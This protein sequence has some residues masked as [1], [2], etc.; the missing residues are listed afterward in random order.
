MGDL[1]PRDARC[2]GTSSTSSTS[3]TQ[4][5]S[6]LG[7]PSST[8]W[9]QGHQLAHAMSFKFPVFTA[10]HLTQV[11]GPRVGARAISLLYS[12]LS[13][14]PSWRSSA[15]ETLKHSYFRQ[16]SQPSSASS[17]H[18]SLALKPS[19]SRKLSSTPTSARS[20]SPPP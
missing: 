18:L 7:T 12:T 5:C 4:V 1:T 6:V 17:A 10:T 3:T 14:N 9:P 13:W 2:L 20:P 16:N 15:Q 11:L 19:R 8:D